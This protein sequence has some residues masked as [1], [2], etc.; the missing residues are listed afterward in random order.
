MIFRK[1]FFFFFISLSV[2][3]QTVHKR[4]VKLLIGGDVMFNWG[5]SETKEKHGQNSSVIQLKNIFLEA[6]FRAVNLE[7][8]VAKTAKPDPTKP[9]VFNATR[10]DL[11]SLKDIGVDLVFLGNNHTMDYGE[12]GL[13]ET[14]D[15]LSGM[16]FLFVGA[17]KN[18]K[19]AQSPKKIQVQGTY[20]QFFSV[21]DIGEKRLFAAKEKPGIAPFSLE[22]IS[23]QSNSQGVKILSIHW[24]E[25]YKPS[26]YPFQI[27][28]AHTLI[29]SGFKVIV[30]HHPHIPQGI[31]KF[32]NGIIFYSLGNLIFGSRN[33]YLNHNFVSILHFEDDELTLCEIVPIFGKFQNSDHIVRPLAKEEANEFLQELSILS[34]KL[35]T[36][37]VIKKGRGYIYFRKE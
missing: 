4:Y 34:Q 3:G 23:N 22:Q 11:L 15:I 7:S 24:G 21:S 37:I 36:E 32:R 8:A 19:E 1:I 13:T 31:E 12:K 14:L 9:Y 35:N 27:K 30:G 20:F 25:E 2:Y 28:K 10:E 26:P 29:D 33:T 6:D 18:L 16:D 5:I 17:G